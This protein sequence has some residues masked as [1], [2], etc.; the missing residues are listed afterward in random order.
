MKIRS[1]IAMVLAYIVPGAGHL[2]L[3]KRARAA[4]YF[5]IVVLMFVIGLAVDG[6]IYT[7][8]ESNGLLR[9]LASLGSMGSGLLYFLAKLKPALA[10]GQVLV[11][12]FEYG[13]TFTLTAGLMNLLLM[14]DVYDISE[15]RKP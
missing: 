3:G 14:L 6:G 9:L 5:A 15:G 8:A 12:T 1:L 11:D 7:I 10:G 2:F 13:R 4:A